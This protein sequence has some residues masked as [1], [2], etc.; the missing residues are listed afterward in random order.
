M[1]QAAG[2]SRQDE[3]KSDVLWKPLLRGF[4]TYYRERVRVAVP[5]LKL[6]RQTQGRSLIRVER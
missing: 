6:L 1:A 5:S 2:Y 4:R 3:I